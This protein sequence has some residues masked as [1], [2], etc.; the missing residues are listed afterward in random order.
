VSVF[1]EEGRNIKLAKAY[2]D[3]A[4]KPNESTTGKMTITIPPLML[5]KGTY[6]IVVAVRD[7]LTDHVGVTAQKI[8][9]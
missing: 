2:A 9:V 4:L 7:E 1:D 8:S 3:I 5:S 6:R